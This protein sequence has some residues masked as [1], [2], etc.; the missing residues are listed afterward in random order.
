MKV[1]V[2]FKQ[3]AEKIL[4]EQNLLAM[5]HDDFLACWISFQTYDRRG[6]KIKIYVFAKF[7]IPISADTL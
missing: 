4:I 1:A 5:L 6:S 7:L 3:L 2:L